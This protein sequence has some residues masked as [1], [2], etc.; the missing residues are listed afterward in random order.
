MD[1]LR[2]SGTPDF[3]CSLLALGHFMRLS[4]M[5]AAHADLG[6]APCRKSGTI[7]GIKR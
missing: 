5:K 1:V 7:N 6:G 2:N 4:S 3:L